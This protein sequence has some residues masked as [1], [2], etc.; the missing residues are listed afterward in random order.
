M[1]KINGYFKWYNI[2]IATTVVGY[3]YRLKEKLKG[4]KILETPI[5]QE[6]LSCLEND[7]TVSE[8]MRKFFVVNNNI[9]SY[10]IVS[11][12]QMGDYLEIVI[13]YK[14]GGRDLV[15]KTALKGKKWSELK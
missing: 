6:I 11:Q 7:E 13:P 3:F 10:K 12:S 8:Y 4:D 15:V 14:Y 9:L 5:Y 2:T 1:N